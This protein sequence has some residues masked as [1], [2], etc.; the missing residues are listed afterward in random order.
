MSI[1]VLDLQDA[2]LAGK[3]EFRAFQ[4]EWLT[5]WLRP[6]ME[7]VITRRNE[8]IMLEWDRMPPELHVAMQTQFPD[9]Y[10]Q[11]EEA[12]REMR[13]KYK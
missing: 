11:A 10:A 9:K 13:E 4:R 1:T 2:R 3:M 12:V 7:I 6:L 5:Q 8:R